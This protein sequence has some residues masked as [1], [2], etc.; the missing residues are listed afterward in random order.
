MRILLIFFFVL[1]SSNLYAQD[2]KWPKY[3]TKK[4]PAELLNKIDEGSNGEV[5][6]ML[7]EYKSELNSNP[8]FRIELPLPVTVI[9]EKDS[10]YERFEE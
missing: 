4:I 8:A 3:L 2:T 6:Q 9:S 10:S 5:S 7:K 1:I